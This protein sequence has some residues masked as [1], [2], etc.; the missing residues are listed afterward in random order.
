MITLTAPN[1]EQINI[2]GSLVK[3]ARRAIAGESLREGARTRIDWVEML[4]VREPIE[5]VAAAV[6]AEL[7]TFTRVT[8]RDGS[9]IWFNG[10][11]AT[12]PL[13]LTPSQK[14]GI[15]KSAIKLLNYR[16]YVVETPAEVRA[17]LE[18][19]GGEVLP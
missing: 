9:K 13:I 5:M 18:E 17:I 8:S 1:G 4:L 10:R 7:A 2:A 11:L 19:S 12:G 3:R 14:D 15:V 16:Q 6:Q